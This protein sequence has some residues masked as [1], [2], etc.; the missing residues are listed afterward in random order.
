MTLKID[1]NPDIERLLI[2]GR[3]AA[4]GELLGIA[5]NRGLPVTGDTEEKY[6]GGSDGFI[7]VGGLNILPV[8]D[9]TILEVVVQVGRPRRGH[10]W[11]FWA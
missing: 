3:R 5:K 6:L 8:I 2:A 7:G 9:A 10:W 4:Y 1:A 11:K